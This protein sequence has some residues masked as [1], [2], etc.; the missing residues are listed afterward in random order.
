MKPLKYDYAIWQRIKADR[1]H[2][3][4]N[5]SAPRPNWM[6]G[7]PSSLTAFMQ[8]YP[9]V[10]YRKSVPL[11]PFSYGSSADVDISISPFARVMLDMTEY[12]LARRPC[13]VTGQGWIR[14]VGFSDIIDTILALK[15]PVVPT[16]PPPQGQVS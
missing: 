11:R 9:Y 14:A 3:L 2:A 15:K 13:F 6:I 5:P 8:G 4:A 1:D 7:R 12:A 16:T 10:V